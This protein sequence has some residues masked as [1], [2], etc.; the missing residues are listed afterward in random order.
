MIIKIKCK[1]EFLLDIL[2]RNP[3]TDFGIYARPLKKGV[4][5]G[6][7]VTSHQY[8]IVFQDTKYSYLPE[9]SNQ[10]DFQSYCSPLVVMDICTDFFSHLLKAKNEVMSKEL[11]WLHRTIGDIDIE[12]CTIEIPSFYINSN[13][14][15]NELFLLSKYFEGVTTQY[16]KGHNFKLVIEANSVFDAINLLSLTALFTHITN[17]YGIYTYIDESFADKY[18]RILTNLDNVPYFVFYLFIKRAVR[19]EKLFLMVKP[20]FESYLL[21]QGLNTKLTWYPTHQARIIYIIDKLDF[22]IPILDIGCGELLYYKKVMSKGFKQSYYAVDSDEKFEDIATAIGARY[23]ENNLSFFSDLNQY[24]DQEKVNIIMSEVIEHNTKE[25]ALSLIKRTLS[26]NF[27]SI[28]VTTPNA[29][30]N[31]YYSETMERRHDDHQ[32]EP[33]ADEFRQLIVDSVIDV[34][35]LEICFDFIGDNINGVQPTQ[36]CIITKKEVK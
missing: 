15:R 33:S 25:N 14:V 32:F 10:I 3:N 34:P 4:V 35:N 28:I 31:K 2:N 18:A 21:K 12:K 5:I 7:V 11:S 36:V 26:L 29:D 20:V 17:E 22:N 6:Q 23:S 9:E 8:D 19:S 13:W 1:N 30:F 16:Q 24:P 27:A